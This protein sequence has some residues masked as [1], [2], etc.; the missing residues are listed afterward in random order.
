MMMFKS[1]LIETGAEI[2]KV[3]RA[4]E[5]IIPTLVFPVAFYFMFGVILAGSSNNA[6]YLLATY[7]IFAVMGPAIF[8]FGVST[9]TE[10]DKGWL[11]LKRAAPAPAINYIVAKIIATV[12]FAALSLVALYIVG[13]FVGGVVLPRQTWALLLLT[14]MLAT[15]PF[16]L[17][18]LTLGF[19]LN[20]NAAVAFANIVF[21]G[22]A[23]LGGLWIPIFV[24]P[25]IM[26]T[27]AKFLPTYHLGEIA[28]T[29][30]GQPAAPGQ[31]EREISGHIAMTINMT[32]GL[33]ALTVFAWTRQRK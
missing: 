5:Y 28:L 17:I 8:G 29:V 14:H 16:I 24:F 15:L 31:G 11:T 1:L 30:S 20:A 25:E 32:I 10:R 9:A 4:P 26:Q 18:G 7:G 3:A 33:T 22:L 2:L 19:L 12:I 23:V 13:G 6:S 21:M 27:M